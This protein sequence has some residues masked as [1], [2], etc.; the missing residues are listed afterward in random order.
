MAFGGD[1]GITRLQADG[2]VTVDLGREYEL[3]SV[4]VTFSSVPDQAVLLADR[5]PSSG[6]A[7][8][9]WAPLE[10]YAEDCVGTFG[11]EEKQFASE[12][13]GV[14]CSKLS[15]GAP[16]SLAFTIFLSTQRPEDFLF[17][18]EVFDYTT[19]RVLQLR[20]P[21]P[22]AVLDVRV[23]GRPNCN[24]HASSVLAV[25]SRACECE[26]DTAGPNCE[27][28]APLFNGRPWRRSTGSTGFE[29]ARCE[30]HRHASACEYDREIEGGVCID[31][32]DHTQGEQCDSCVAGFYREPGAP[33]DGP[34]VCTPCANCDASGVMPEVCVSDVF[35][36]GAGEVP[37]D[38][39]CKA[40][41]SGV[42]CDR[43]SAGF[44]GLS[45]ADPLGCQV[46]ACDARGTEPEDL[47]TNCGTGGCV[48]K[49]N[50]EGTACD[51]CKRGFYGGPSSTDPAGCMS[52]G[53]YPTG[54]LDGGA[55]CDSEGQCNCAPGYTGRDC[56]S[57]DAAH[58]AT[59]LEGGSHECTPCGCDAIGAN[60]DS[61]D[62]AG[63]CDCALDRIAGAKCDTCAQGFYLVAG[64]AGG[65]WSCSPCDCDAAGST[66]G[67]CS[68]ET[69]QC[70]CKAFTEGRACDACQDGTAVLDAANPLGCSGTPL[71]PSALE[72]V[73]Q[74]TAAGGYEAVITWDA[75][76]LF[77]GPVRSYHVSR[78]DLE[79]GTTNPAR[80]VSATELVDETIVPGR[81]YAYTVWAETDKGIGGTETATLEVPETPP[82]PPGGVTA[83][84]TPRTVTVTFGAPTD[85]N[86]VITSY[87][88]SM[89]LR[90]Q[91]ETPVI[92]ATVLR[93]ATEHTLTGLLPFTQYDAGVVACNQGGGCGMTAFAEVDTAVA[94]PEGIAQIEVDTDYG[95]YQVVAR[96]SPPERQNGESGGCTLS[97]GVAGAALVAAYTGDALQFTQATLANT[98]YLF[99]LVCY[100]VGVDDG[101]AGPLTRAVTP[102]DSPEGVQAPEILS[103]TQRSV[104]ARLAEPEQPN[105]IVTRHALLV[106]GLQ[107]DGGAA[108]GVYE[109]SGLVPGRQYALAAVACT[110]DGCGTSGSITVTMQP[111]PPEGQGAPAVEWGGQETLVITWSP[112]AHPNGAIAYYSLLRDGA[113]VAVYDGS[114]VLQHEDSG[115]G[116]YV[117]YEYTV[118][119]VAEIG[120]AAHVAASPPTA[121]RTLPAA[122]TA[123]PAPDVTILTGYAATVHAAA[124]V[125][126]NGPLV[127][128]TVFAKLSGATP[129]AY[130]E[131]AAAGPGPSGALWP[132]ADWLD[133]AHDIPISG[134]HPLSAYDLY[135]SFD[136]GEGTALSPVVT[137]SKDGECVTAHA[138]L[139]TPAR[140][141]LDLYGVPF[142]R[143]RVRSQD[144]C[145]LG[146]V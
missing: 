43:C 58:F 125:P 100:T 86:G 45:A 25:G 37:G 133:A 113:E 50:V 115:L 23:V 110:D 30:C 10:F 44:M 143:R 57:C 41:V 4:E 93:T 59:A 146:H 128:Y 121:A 17:S 78:L 29:C 22:S 94:A 1:S 65:D 131:I 67:P 102:K 38:C 142:R 55:E 127:Q 27:R 88:V 48:C 71:P 81:T 144:I 70:P 26:D 69:G 20:T 109:A 36:A 75:P 6:G 124:A 42:D 60:S 91:H 112:P 89:Y 117:E 118:L 21:D 82:G 138:C 98:E 84:A 7:A 39:R 3:F 56:A 74:A 119:A 28:C 33:L 47:A 87:V 132:D 16:G 76:A 79:S 64:A 35:Q 11:M 85:P 52:C 54:T 134:L 46:C 68:V 77:M 139:G 107:A 123:P 9:S 120:G 136:N 111:A 96:W 61:C 99:Q 95:P 12:V 141:G 2:T 15:P 32:K 40:R 108:P 8:A 129:D 18:D 72:A 137:L 51:V 24:G 80:E 122:P 5:A 116:H 103:V 83:I 105:G 104:R 97:V 34:D 66:D 73:A 62:A 63:A 140:S 53:C 101:T 19:L 126:P 114:A 106:D 92:S 14:I 31:C 49:A 130:A 90:G 145:L 13:T 135:I